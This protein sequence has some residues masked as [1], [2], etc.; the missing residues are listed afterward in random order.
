MVK[1]IYLG[2][3]AFKIEGSKV[4][5]IDPFITGNPKSPIGDVN[6]VDK[7]DVVIVTHDHGDHGFEDAVKICKKTGA[8]F[9]SQYEL[10]VKSGLQK[11]EP[12]N[13]GGFV[14]VGGLGVEVA[15]TPAW[16]T[17]QLGD[18][19]G[20]IVKI[21]G[22]TIYHAGDTGLFSDM[23]LIGELY[24]PDLALLPIGSRFTMDVFQAAKAVEFISPK[25]VIPMHYNTFD[26]IKADPEEFK[27]L[28]GD[29]AHVVIL[30]PGESFEI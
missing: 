11:V 6:K 15:F 26:L 23:K 5:F 19:T 16:H 14:N 18:P 29:K 7:A 4:I 10:V 27:K 20:V 9:V 30:N 3:S 8:Y 17:A 12:M 21:D 24:K 1:I 2:H 28:V 22:K 25:Y 13:I